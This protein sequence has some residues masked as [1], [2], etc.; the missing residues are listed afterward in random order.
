[1]VGMEEGLGGG[2]GGETMVGMEEGLEGGEG[3]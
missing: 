2:E 3:R 1:M